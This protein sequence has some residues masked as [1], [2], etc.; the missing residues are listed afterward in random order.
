[1]TTSQAAKT[2]VISKIISSVGL[3]L[4]ICV[5]GLS[6]WSGQDYRNSAKWRDHTDTV[7]SEIRGFKASLESAESNQRGYLITAQPV[8]LETYQIARNDFEKK[9]SF[10]KTLTAE[11]P[12]QREK[13]NQLSSVLTE[14]I[15]ML[16][17]GIDFVKQGEPSKAATLV[18]D[19]HGRELMTLLREQLTALEETEQAI[20]LTRATKAEEDF[21][22]TSVIAIA[23]LLI[24]FV[25]LLFSRFLINR[26]IRLREQT[27]TELQVASRK[28]LEAS[29]LKSTFLANMSHEIRTPL[30]GIIG[31]SKLLEQ[32]ELNDRQRDYVETVKTSSNALLALINEILDLSKIESGKL[33]LEDATFELKSLLKS[34]ISIVDFSAKTK[35]LQVA[36]EI[37]HDVSEFFIGDPLRLRQVLLNL[38]NNAIKFSERGTITMKV[39]KRGEADSKATL[40]FEIVDQGMGLD[41]ETRAKLFQ[42]FTQG[43]DSMSRKFGGTG[44][45]LAISKQ[46]V[47]MMNGTID[48]ES[49]K[50]IGSRFFFEVSLKVAK[51]DDS[52]QPVSFDKMALKNLHGF[53]LI[54]EDNKVNQKVVAEM[55]S[56]LGCQSK[57]AENGELAIEAMKKFDFNL[58]LMDGQMPV[59]DGYEATRLIRE[60]RA[61]ETNKLIPIL[62]TTANAIKGDI[63]RCLEAGMND[64]ISKPISYDDLAFKVE[65]WMT[66]GKSVIDETAI[67]KLVQ[68][69]TRR[70]KSLLNELIVLFLNESPKDLQKMRA[71]MNESNLPEMS[72]IA[73][74]LKSSAANLGALR[75]RELAERV[76]RAKADTSAQQLQFLMDSLDKELKNVMDDLQRRI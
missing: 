55:V 70:G 13:L 60:G 39:S 69:G 7:I 50:G 25:L 31:M 52:V 54:V 58:V 36:T 74:S 75:L 59:M 43:D 26:E 14:K 8:F 49:I 45:G 42:S 68:L 32:T 41:S 4:V 16:E 34:T 76:E 46:I 53:V 18:R 30:N 1:M 48:V 22:R 71:F 56:L 21:A 65:K 3:I 40:L 33:Q 47:E 28:A 61:G 66:R 73:H 20:L 17:R 38:L 67:A 23:G 62:A 51:Y 9:L 37:A 12:D 5:A 63:E 64:Y 35:G 10:L 6:Y 19:G 11:N 15:Q 24:A 2:G 72:A 44:L 29:N 57:I 27:E